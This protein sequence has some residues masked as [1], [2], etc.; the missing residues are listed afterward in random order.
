MAHG[1]RTVYP[2]EQNKGL[3]SIFQLPEEGWSV[4]RLKHC[5]KH[6]DKDDDNSLKNV[7][8]VHN[9]S[10]QKYRHKYIGFARVGFYGIS[11]IVGY[12]M[13]NPLYIY[14]YIYIYVCMICKHIL[15]LSSFYT[16]LIGFKYCN[17]TVIF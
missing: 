11:T 1:T 16:Q 5:A 6:G 9:I 2:G 17:I 4:Q 15:C 7:Y 3:S 12:L 8:N 10:S 13:P 14:I